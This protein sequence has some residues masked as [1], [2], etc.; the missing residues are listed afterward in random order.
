MPYKNIEDKKEHFKSYY[1]LNKERILARKKELYLLNADKNIAYSKQYRIENKDSLQQKKNVYVKERI[2]NDNVYKLRNSVRGLIKNSIKSRGYKKNTK[3]A[4]ILGCTIEEFKLHL[5]SQFEDWMTWENYGNWN[6]IPDRP[7]MAW[8]IDHKVPSSS[9]NSE[10]EV[11][12]LNHFTNLQPMCS[13]VN[14]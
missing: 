7:N 12:K 14:R 13:Y 3:T 10:D 5:E 6:G 1:Q 8:D 4:E 9:G 2:S 11:L